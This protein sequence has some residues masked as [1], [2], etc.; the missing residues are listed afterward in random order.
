M[1][2]EIRTPLTAILGFAEILLTEGDLSRAPPHRIEAIN[3][4]LRNS[5]H[6]LSILNDILDLSK[7]EAGR[8]EV[9]R[10]ACSPVQVVADV[11]HLMQVRADAKRLPLLGGIRRPDAGDHP[12]RSD[13]PAADAHQPVGNAVKFTEKGSVRLVVRTLPDRERRADAAIRRS[14]TRASA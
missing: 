3:A 6:L 5:S 10:V 1:S 4:I 8:L 7:I 9:E 14:S 13:P 12:Q 11:L 2:H